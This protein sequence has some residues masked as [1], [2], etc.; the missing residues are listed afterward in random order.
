M[1]G[2]ELLAVDGTRI[3]AV[4]SRERNFT[5]SRLD[6]RLKK[7]DERLERYLK[8]M[9]EADAQDSGGGKTATD[10]AE[11]IESLSKRRASLQRPVTT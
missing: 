1:Y 2:R 3:K 8:E 9:D 7:T 5:R 4:N 6:Y 10:L 11:R